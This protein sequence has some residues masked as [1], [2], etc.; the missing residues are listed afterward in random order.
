M[1]VYFTCENSC[2]KLKIYIIWSFGNISDNFAS[3]LAIGAD[4]LRLEDAAGGGDT[5]GNRG[6]YYCL[7]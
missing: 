4:R 7:K 2:T 1:F 3:E 5:P 6:S